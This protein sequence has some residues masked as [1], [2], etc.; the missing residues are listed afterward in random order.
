MTH[1]DSRLVRRSGRTHA[2]E[3]VSIPSPPCVIS[4]SRGARDVLYHTRDHR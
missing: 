2:S 3:R 4:L 1:D